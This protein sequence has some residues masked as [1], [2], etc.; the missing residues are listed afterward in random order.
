MTYS[1]YNKLDKRSKLVLVYHDAQKL[2]SIFPYTG[3]LRIVSIYKLYNFIV[4]LQC[5]LTADDN[6]ITYAMGHPSYDYL[7]EKYPHHFDKFKREVIMK[8]LR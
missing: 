7:L 4:E 6:G 3:S 8:N 1:E 5:D 2:D